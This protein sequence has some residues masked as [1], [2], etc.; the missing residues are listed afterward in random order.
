MYEVQAELFPERC[1]SPYTLGCA[2]TRCCAGSALGSSGMGQVD[3]PAVH[4]LRG[5]KKMLLL[6][7]NFCAEMI[8]STPIL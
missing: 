3:A 1:V 4:G 5:R 2:G 7:R 8:F 6:S